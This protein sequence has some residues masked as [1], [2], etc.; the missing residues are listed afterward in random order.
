MQIRDMLLCDIDAVTAIGLKALKRMGEEADE[1]KVRHTLSMC[2][3]M[4]LVAENELGI[5]GCIALVLSEKPWSREQQLVEISLFTAKGDAGIGVLKGLL[6]AAINK[7]QALG[8]PFV[9]GTYYN[10][11]PDKFGKVLSIL[12]LKQKGATF[13]V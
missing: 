5:V 10:R 11:N 1:S 3:P 2:Q 7:A 8:V 4:S 6:K 13:Y 9:T 12:G